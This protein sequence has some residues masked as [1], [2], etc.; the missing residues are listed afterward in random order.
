MYISC[1]GE[2]KSYEG[3]KQWAEA[4]YR[5]CDMELPATWFKR[6]VSVAKLRKLG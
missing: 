2:I 1:G 3:W 5:E 6:L 4:M